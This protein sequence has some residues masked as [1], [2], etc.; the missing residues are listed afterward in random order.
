M[1][2]IHCGLHKTASSSIQFALAN[3]RESDDRYISIPD[4][5]DSLDYA[6]IGAR[7]RH[8]ASRRFS[9]LSDERL[10]GSPFDAYD[11]ANERIQLLN[12]AL[13]GRR[14]Q[15][16]IYLRQQPDWLVSVFLQGIQEGRSWS[17]SEFWQ[18][19]RGGPH[20]QWSSLLT[21]LERYS[22]ASRIVVHAYD[23]SQD[24][25]QDFFDV[26]GLGKAPQTSLGRINI[27]P[28]ITALQSPVL[29]AL[30]AHV[31]SDEEQVLLRNLF[32][33]ASSTSAG[34]SL[35]PFPRD[36]QHELNQY[37]RDDWSNLI[38]ILQSASLTTDR[39]T[40]DQVESWGDLERPFAG[41]SLNDDA[42]REELLR[43]V[44]RWGGDS[45]PP[46]RRHI[47]R[48]TGVWKESG[49]AGV[50]DIVRYKLAR[51]R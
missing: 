36:L 43:M 31:G 49:V 33:N 15:V 1:I 45:R 42:V 48:V 28:S 21:N 17:P 32:Q 14:Y 37:F 19:L 50:T 12:D 38:T 8:V 16:L 22:G 29:A 7:L 20:L 4:S 47:H 5:S 13:V 25:V 39:A 40:I 30:N 18:Q 2:T 34:R 46:G 35:S 3:V 27:N 41:S 10:L 6:G 26:C 51:R 44:L 9:I 24:M 23:A 11:L